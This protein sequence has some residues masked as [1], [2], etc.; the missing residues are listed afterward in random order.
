MVIFKSC[1]CTA[2]LSSGT[3]HA[4]ESHAESHRCEPKSNELAM[5]CIHLLALPIHAPTASEIRPSPAGHSRQPARRKLALDLVMSSLLHI[6]SDDPAPPDSTSLTSLHMKRLIVLTLLQASTAILTTSSMPVKRK[7]AVI[8][9]S[10]P[11]RM[12]SPRLQKAT[13]PSSMITEAKTSPTHHA[14]FLD[15]VPLPTSRPSSPHAADETYSSKILLLPKPHTSS[16]KKRTHQ[17]LKSTSRPL[18]GDS[19]RHY[20]LLVREALTLTSPQQ[21]KE[22]SSST[23]YPISQSKDD[24]EYNHAIRPGHDDLPPA[25]LKDAFPFH[26]RSRDGPGAS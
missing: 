7:Q 8:P 10:S 14:S 4:P 1:H 11:R 22:G 21:E 6:S 25:P 19:N 3:V 26:T 17:Q 12:V 13:S 18:D 5:T 9:P 23:L 2:H 20:K 16:A 24:S 15:F